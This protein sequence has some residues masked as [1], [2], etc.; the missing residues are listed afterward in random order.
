MVLPRFV[1]R[2]L[3][4]RPLRVFGDGLQTRC[5]AHVLDVV[6]ALHLLIECPSAAGDVFNI[7]AREEVTVLELAQQV[8]DAVGVTL[9]IELV[10]YRDGCCE[11]RRRVPDVAKVAARIGWTP[12][13]G[14]DAI[15][16]DVVAEHSGILGAAV[17]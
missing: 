5:F 2:A 15:V 4:G 1:E 11:A 12:T 10:P 8:M 14:L 17:A 16:R 9:P 7:G 6:N 13:L 3:S